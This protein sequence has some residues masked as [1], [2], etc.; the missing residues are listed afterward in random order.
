MLPRDTDAPTLPGSGESA[1][2]LLA[3]AVPLAGGEGAAYVEGRRVPDV[4]ADGAGVRFLPVL[5]G[6]PAVVAPLLGPQGE[7]RAVHG[8]WLHHLPKMI[9]I[10]RAGGV[11]APPGSLESD[12]LVLVEGLFDSLS[13]LACGVL[14]VAVIGKWIEWLP[15][16][17]GGRTVVLAFDGNRPGDAAAREYA[18]RLEEGRWHRLRPPAG[19]KDWNNA[20][21]KTGIRALASW[22]SRHPLLASVGGR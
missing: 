9:N 22:L 17:V 15:R 8:R 12:P 11:F 2:A 14:S 18:A 21:R 20:L 16:A 10:G 13:L 5:L 19:I 4:V 3:R 7:L 1:A 6:R